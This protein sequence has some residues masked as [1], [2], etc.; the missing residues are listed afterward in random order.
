MSENE[1]T[2]KITRTIDAPVA[3]VWQAWTTPSQ[4]ETWAYSKPGSVEMDLRPGGSWKG[5]VVTPDGGEFPISGSYLE[6][7]E[8]KRLVAGMDIPGLDEQETMAV[9]LVDKGDQTEITL[10]QVSSTAEGRDQAE[11]GSGLLLDGLAAFLASA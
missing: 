2:Y 5:V 7:E 10:S 4:Y 9:D 11:Q 1:F 8:N 6:V 3:K